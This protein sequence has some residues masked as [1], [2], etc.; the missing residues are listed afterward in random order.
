MSFLS[1]LLR[2]QP[3]RERSFG[4]DDLDIKLKP[5]LN[6]EGGFF[7][8]AGANDG[9]IQ[10]NTYY[11]EQF[12]KWR[13]ILVEPIPEKSELCRK[14]RCHSIVENYALVPFDFKGDV[15]DMHYCNLMSLVK[16]AMKSDQADLDHINLGCEVQKIKTREITVPATTLTSL[17][18]RHNIE[19]I[20]FF[21]LDVEGYELNVLKGLDLDRHRP[22]WMLIEAR[23]RE[24]I[25]SHL[26]SYYELV[27]TLS[28]HD[29][30]FKALNPL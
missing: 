30:L 24:E 19:K 6:F 7:I 5:Y 9:I 20:D 17:L 28:H 2:K 18:D 16:G 3:E 12:K 27:A 10:S 22:N 26:R 13:G 21:S 1:R 4:L 23:H 8:E 14:N 29:V 15:V 25:E 11:Y